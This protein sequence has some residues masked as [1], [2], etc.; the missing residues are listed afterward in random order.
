MGSAC[1]PASDTFASEDPIRSGLKTMMPDSLQVPPRPS[2]ALATTTGAP[3]ANA[4]FINF[5]RAK[6]PTDFPSGDQNGCFAPSVPGIILGSSESNVRTNNRE[7]DASSPANTM[8]WPSGD[9]T[10]AEF[11][12]TPAG[13]DHADLMRVT[14]V[15]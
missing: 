15:G 8:D 12:P 7:P 5:P 11:S 6:N 3:S 9:T 1:P 2:G 10:G 14:G 4:T 13:S